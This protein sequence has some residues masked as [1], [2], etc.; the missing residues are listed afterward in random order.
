M[1]ILLG[2]QSNALKITEKGRVEVQ[3]E[4]EEV[5]NDQFIKVSVKDTGVGI[6][7]D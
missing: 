1:Q 7:L 6:P 5:S 2:L 3:V 4:I